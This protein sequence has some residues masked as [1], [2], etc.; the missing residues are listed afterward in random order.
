MARPRGLQV[1][2]DRRAR[3]AQR[4]YRACVPAC[5]GLAW[6]GASS[7]ASWAR[8]RTRGSRASVSWGRGRTGGRWALCRESLPTTEQEQGEPTSLL[9]SPRLRKWCTDRRVGGADEVGASVRAAAARVGRVVGEGAVL[10][11]A[12]A[13]RY[14]GAACRLRATRVHALRRGPRAGKGCV[15]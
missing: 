11:G 8:A 1:L 14:S 9:V 13:R 3:A 7:R 6:P 12:T 10:G 4:P 15:C 5:G 2:Y